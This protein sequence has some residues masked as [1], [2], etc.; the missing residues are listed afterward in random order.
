MPNSDCKRPR[1]E[2]RI[3]PLAVMVNRP[4][5]SWANPAPTSRAV[6]GE[7]GPD[8]FL[9]QGPQW[10][11]LVGG[12]GQG[13]QGA[14]RDRL[15]DG[16]ETVE[17]IV[18]AQP[19][20]SRRVP[21]R[22]PGEQDPGQ[23]GTQSVDSQ[24]EQG[25]TRHRRQGTRQAEHKQVQRTPD[26]QADRADQEGSHRGIHASTPKSL[27]NPSTSRASCWPRPG[28]MRTS[29]PSSQTMRC[30]RSRLRR[31]RVNVSTLPPV[32]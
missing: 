23:Q 10:Q 20:K 18:E 16:A 31:S 1:R 2:A 14:Q 13:A 19:E 21:V 30:V 5:R 11:S 8:V 3:W 4:A 32:L 29:S 24:G 26:G 15:V 6:R 28:V 12:M 7:T 25:L 17:L 27:R 22:N 9:H